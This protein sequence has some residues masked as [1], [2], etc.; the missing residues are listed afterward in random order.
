MLLS[1]TTF[2]F[3]FS[4]LLIRSFFFIALISSN[5]NSKRFVALSAIMINQ[6]HVEELKISLEHQYKK[7]KHVFTL[8]MLATNCEEK[9]NLEEKVNPS[10]LEDDFASGTDPSIFI[11]KTIVIRPI[12]RNQLHFPSIEINKPLLTP[13]HSVS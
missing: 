2:P 8:R 3:N 9:V 13:V 4:V 10:I 11:N 6:A 1:T 7:T 12:K 5:D